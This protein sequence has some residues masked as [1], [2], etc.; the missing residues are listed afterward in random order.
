MNIIADIFNTVIDY[1]VSVFII[2]SLI[3]S[4]FVCKDV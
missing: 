4:P 3:A 1:L 2:Q